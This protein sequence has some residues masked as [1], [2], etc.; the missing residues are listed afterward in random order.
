[1]Q[2]HVHGTGGFAVA[3]LLAILAVLAGLGAYLVAAHR[4]RRNGIDWP[5][6]RDG[7]AIV[8]AIGLVAV[9][10]PWAGGGFLAHMVRHVVV[11]MV[12][13]L[14][15]VVALPGTLTLRA[16][17]G[18][19]RRRVLA[20]LH[21][22][23]VSW[24]V[25]P[26]VTALLTVGSIFLLYRTPLLAA[27]L[28]APWL[29]DLVHVHLLM[30]GVLFTVAVCQLDPLR[31]R[32]SLPLRATTM[33]A[34]AAAHSVV[35]KGLYA[36]PPPNTAFDTADLQA[37]A[38]LMYYSGDV[39]EIGMAIVLGVTWYAAGGRALASARRRAGRMGAA[40]DAS[41]MDG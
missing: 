26:P 27:S 10:A 34:A 7:C 35:A 14:F 8:A 31:R 41:R 21:S 13:P 22:R 37:G 9:S 4:L 33:V 29:H 23:P 16:L 20:V 25:V 3:Q 18:P 17:R 28:A 32:Y 5:R 24:L 19:R 30:T 2:T 39:V 1:M 12:S 40:G 6:Y 11:G 36:T 15:L 38:Q